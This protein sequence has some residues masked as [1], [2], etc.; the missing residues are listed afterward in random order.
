[1]PDILNALDIHIFSSSSES[2]GNITAE[3]MACSV[4][5][6]MTNVGEADNLLREFGWIVQTNNFVQLAE[7]I[8]QVYLKFK[9]EKSWLLRKFSC[10]KKIIHDYSVERMIQSYTELWV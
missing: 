10:R 9:D 3:A 5:C 6:I 8:E 4:P 7:T 2:F 1:V